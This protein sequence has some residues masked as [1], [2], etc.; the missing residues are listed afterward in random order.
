MTVPVALRLF[1]DPSGGQSSFGGLFAMVLVSIGPVLGFF[2]ASQRR[3]TPDIQAHYVYS[4]RELSRWVRGLYEH[5][6]PIDDTVTLEGLVRVWAHEGL[7]LFRDRLVGEDEK[8][9]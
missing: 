3:F 9:E 8:G 4:P 1:L 6:K 5:L 7:R 2:L